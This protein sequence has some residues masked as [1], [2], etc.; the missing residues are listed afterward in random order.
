[1]KT[2]TEQAIQALREKLRVKEEDAR[3]L[4]VVLNAFYTD[5]G[6]PAPYPDVNAEAAS[7]SL[8]ALRSDLFYGNTIAEAAKIYLE[9]RKASGFGSAPVNDIYNALKAGGYKFD[10]AN[11]ENAKN[12]LRISLRKNSSIFHQLP[13]GDYGL[14]VWYGI[15]GGKEKTQP[16]RKRGVKHRKLKSKAQQ[17]EKEP[18][19][20]ENEAAENAVAFTVDAFEKFVRVK[21]RRV[22]DVT[23]HFN[24]TKAVVKKLLDPASKVY[25]AGVGWLKVREWRNEDFGGV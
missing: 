4:K 12:G 10:T 19:V 15:D 7:V 5:E 22:K 23:A 17:S 9:M 3:Q 20:G 21:A 14:C 18:K 6:Q 13:A 2:E 1:M 25:L 24:V 11:E 8:G 16:V